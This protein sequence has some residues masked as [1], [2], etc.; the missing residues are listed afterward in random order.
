MTDEDPYHLKICSSIANRL[1]RNYHWLEKDDMLSLAWIGVNEAVKTYDET[2]GTKLSTWLSTTGYFKAVDEMRSVKT[3]RKKAQGPGLKFVHISTIE[4]T[5]NEDGFN[6]EN[7][8]QY[9][10][11]PVE[12]YPKEFFKNLPVTIDERLLLKMYYI[13]NISMAQ[14]GLRFGQT[15]SRISQKMYAIREKLS[16]LIDHKGRRLIK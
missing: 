13:D 7:L 9:Q 6:V 1:A 2:R 3:L 11:D 5:D 14:I 10:P 4:G 12:D 15:E 8:L 16:R